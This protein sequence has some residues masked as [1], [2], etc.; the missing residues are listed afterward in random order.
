MAAR[1]LRGGLDL[2]DDGG[3]GG[4]S[5]G[6]AISGRAGGGGGPVAEAASAP[7]A[8][9]PAA[10]AAA[11]M[12]AR[13]SRPHS[14]SATPPRAPTPTPAEALGQAGARLAAAA[15]EQQ[16]LLWQALGGAAPAVA[17]ASASG[18]SALGDAGPGGGGGGLADPEVRHGSTSS[19][20]A[21]R[22]RAGGGNGSGNGNTGAGAAHR[23]RRRRRSAPTQLH[24]AAGAADGPALAAAAL[25]PAL[26]SH[27]LPDCASE[28]EEAVPDGAPDCLAAAAPAPPPAGGGPAAA[29][30]GPPFWL[31]D[32]LDEGWHFGLPIGEGGGGGEGAPC[33]AAQ[34]GSLGSFLFGRRQRSSS[35]AAGAAAGG[36][37]PPAG[38]A[39]AASGLLRLPSSLA[40]GVLAPF[41]PSWWA[42]PAATGPRKPLGLKLAEYALPKEVLDAAEIIQVRHPG[43]GGDCGGGGRGRRRVFVGGLPPGAP[44]KPAPQAPGQ[45]LVNA[46]RPPATPQ[47]DILEADEPLDQAAVLFL[48][49]A[50]SGILQDWVRSRGGGAAGR[51]AGLFM[52][53]AGDSCSGQAALCSRRPRSLASGPAPCTRPPL[54]PAP[55]DQ[56]NANLDKVFFVFGAYTGGAGARAHTLTLTHTPHTQLPACWPAN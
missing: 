43:E 47:R 53:W 26:R 15:R 35:A 38:A 14:A 25:T 52:Q 7:A 4:D 20:P 22:P 48:L 50:L 2:T 45:R 41:D 31:A 30:R 12:G 55:R 1:M 36:S 6:G 5:D 11:D 34:P 21:G 37:A 8:A 27:Q 18:G 44:S 16:A 9:A 10:A 13:R 19:E 46:A 49:R 51:Q 28:D 42:A 24:G 33:A 17:G 32:S 23:V 54:V 39:A 56:A 29:R 40:R 3:R